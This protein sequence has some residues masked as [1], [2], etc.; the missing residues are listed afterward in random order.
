MERI[1][2]ARRR[3]LRLDSITSVETWYAVVQAGLA[4]MVVSH[5]ARASSGTDSSSP[6]HSGAG[7]SSPFSCVVR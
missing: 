6:A 5:I 3:K 7:P 4:P 1:E 2:M